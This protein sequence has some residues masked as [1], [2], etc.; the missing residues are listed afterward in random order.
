MKRIHRA[1]RS[2]LWPLAAVVFLGPVTVPADA[3]AGPT[4]SPWKVDGRPAT[5][6]KSETPKTARD[7]GAQRKPKAQR[8]Q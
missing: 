1:D 4:H 5:K 2:W 6:S 8:Q 7:R 3:A